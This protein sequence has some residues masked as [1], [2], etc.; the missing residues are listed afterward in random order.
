MEIV[1]YVWFAAFTYEELGEFIDAGSIFYVADIWNGCDLLI[2]LIGVAF[3]IT[4]EFY[5]DS[6]AEKLGLIK[7]TGIFGLVKDNA[8]IID[9]SF[10]ILSLEALFMV[11][12]YYSYALRKR[13]ANELSRRIC[14]LLSLHPYF[15]TLV[16]ILGLSSRQMLT[17]LD[18][19]LKG[20]GRPYSTVL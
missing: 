14:S 20:D 9:A 7:V 5:L 4:S 19:V 13:A 1:L 17:L 12:R 10:D 8:G 2:I 15:G 3:L 11:P 16:G 18:T 6:T